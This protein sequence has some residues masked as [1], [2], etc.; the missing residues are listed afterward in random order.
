[1]TRNKAFTTAASRRAADP[2]IWTIDGVSLA[3]RAMVDITELGAMA[4]QVVADSDDDGSIASLARRRAVMVDLI[5]SCIVENDRAS[6]RKVAPNIDVP[7]L[8]E[9]VRELFSEYTGA[10]NPTK[11]ESSS[12]GL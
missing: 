6:F 5:E 4:E 1:M 11:P 2:I 8:A 10:G 7:M 3:L 12:D 9:M